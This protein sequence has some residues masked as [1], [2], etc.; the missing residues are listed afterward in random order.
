MLSYNDFLGINS[1]P[2]HRNSI[3]AWS[4]LIPKS[5]PC[6]SEIISTRSKLK[7]LVFDLF[8]YHYRIK[9]T[10][11]VRSSYI[12]LQM[13]G[14]LSTFFQIWAFKSICPCERCR[15]SRGLSLRRSTRLPIRLNGLV[16]LIG[17]YLASSAARHLDCRF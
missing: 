17:Q 14:F 8:D 13:I 4:N 7:G 2:F 3:I 6:N 9:I 11:I 10:R 16:I 1:T 12:N 5:S 15:L